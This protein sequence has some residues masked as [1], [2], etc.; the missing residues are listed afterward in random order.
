MIDPT[1][2][3]EDLFSFVDPRNDPH[4]MIKWAVGGMVQPKKVGSQTS[5]QNL[6]YRSISKP[7]M[8]KFLGRIPKGTKVGKHIVEARLSTSH[9]W[10]TRIIQ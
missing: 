8:M 9:V 6:Y 7:K 2:V 1:L 4:P 5:E 10:R 3:N